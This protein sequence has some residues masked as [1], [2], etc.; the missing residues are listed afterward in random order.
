[1]DVFGRQFFR[2]FC[3]FRSFFIIHV[4][5][6]MQYV[7]PCTAGNEVVFASR[8]VSEAG[9][10][11]M[12]GYLYHCKE[13]AWFRIVITNT[14]AA[15]KLGAKLGEWILSLI[16]NSRKKIVIPLACKIKFSTFV[17]IVSLT[18]PF[19]IVCFSHGA[20]GEISDHSQLDRR[21]H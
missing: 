18:L 12:P 8:L 10:C 17:M 20:P 4:P 19:T 16:D 3:R 2:S 13:P 1:M 7:Q 5:F 21:V 11:L 6:I 9:V 15:I 14:E